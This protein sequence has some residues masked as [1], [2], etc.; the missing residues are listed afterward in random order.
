MSKKQV[1]ERIAE[2]FNVTVDV[3]VTGRSMSSQV[4]KLE[5]KYKEVEDNNCC[6]S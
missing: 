3:T 4:D 2:Y 1:L 5:Q 6:I